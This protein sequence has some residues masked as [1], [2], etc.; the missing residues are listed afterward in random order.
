MGQKNNRIE[1]EAVHLPSLS[2]C[3]GTML[4]ALYAD[5][6]LVFKVIL[7]PFRATQVQPFLLNVFTS[8]PEKFKL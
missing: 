7:C 1:A 4:W 8:S 5:L 3:L 6:S 2:A